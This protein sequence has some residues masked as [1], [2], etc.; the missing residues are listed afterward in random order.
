M[1]HRVLPL[2]FDATLVG[3]LPVR[4]HHANRCSE[5]R[6]V[7]PEGLRATAREIHISIHFHCSLS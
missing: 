2:R 7:V 5:V 4:H 1:Q 3:R 6:L